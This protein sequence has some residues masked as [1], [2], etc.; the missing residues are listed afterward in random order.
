MDREQQFIAHDAAGIMNSIQQQAFRTDS[1]LYSCRDAQASA[2][3]Y[4]IEVHNLDL[5]SS[6][7][8][9]YYS[10]RHCFLEYVA[11]PEHSLSARYAGGIDHRSIGQLIFIPPGV[12]L[13]WHWEKGLQRTVTCMFE[14]ERI[15]M[16]GGYD[17]R[18]DNIDLPTTF[19]IRNDYLLMGMRKL[20]EEVC[21]PGFGS[22]LQIENMLA[23]MGIELHREFMNSRP[24]IELNPGR[25]STRQLNLVRNYIY[26]N[27]SEEVSINSI[28]SHCGLS[29]RELSEQ[30]KNTLGTTLR[31]FV[32][33]ARVDKAKVLLANHQ[34]M[35]KQVGY[36]C[37]FKGA[38]AFVA[39]FKKTTGVT[40]AEY[41]RRYC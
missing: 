7:R 34:L 4:D 40:P 9:V 5:P 12:E 3:A 11:V 18:W 29:A 25:L 35:I 21:S 15:A 38:A 23:V 22:E 31:Q 6:G 17:W 30:F 2:P 32:A 33:S 10:E 36:G 41:R 1:E 39:A 27:L 26:D 20:G 16:L 19:N 28:A 24:V 13:E 14:I 8:G 37:G